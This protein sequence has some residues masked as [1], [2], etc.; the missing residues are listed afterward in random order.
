[1]GNK[2]R[3]KTYK[4]HHTKQTHQNTGKE[5]LSLDQGSAEF[6][7]YEEDLQEVNPLKPNDKEYEALKEYN[8]E[9]DDRLAIKAEEASRHATGT[10]KRQYR[11]HM[12]K[13]SQFGTM[14]HTAMHE[15][16][17]TPDKVDDA[18]AR[19]IQEA[20]AIVEG[21]VYDDGVS[22]EGYVPRAIAKYLG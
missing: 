7:E 19:R 3:I 10:N 6:R 21:L 16:A 22:E 12:N 4:D 20:D 2:R 15:A 17:E 9:H 18:I 14:K 13:E 11:L 8:S 1:M 5:Q